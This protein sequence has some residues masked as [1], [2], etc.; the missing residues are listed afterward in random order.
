MVR[1]LRKVKEDKE[2]KEAK[3]IGEVHA[4][5]LVS[6][7]LLNK[8]AQLDQLD[9][10]NQLDQLSQLDQLHVWDHLQNKVVVIGGSKGSLN[11]SLHLKKLLLERIMI[12][13]VQMI[14]TVMTGIVT[15]IPTMMITIKETHT[16]LLMT[17]AGISTAGATIPTSISWRRTLIIRILFQTRLRI[18]CMTMA[19]INNSTSQKT[20]KMIMQDIIHAFLTLESQ[21][22]MQDKVVEFLYAVQD[23]SSRHS[24]KRNSA[25]TRQTTVIK[26]TSITMTTVINI[27]MN[28]VKN[29]SSSSQTWMRQRCNQWNMLHLT[30]TTRSSTISMIHMIMSTYSTMSSQSSIT[31][32]EETCSKVMTSMDMIIAQLHI[33]QW[34]IKVIQWVTKVIL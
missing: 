17:T 9:K 33:T 10:L 16:M 2:V 11:R 24:H 5:P 15:M 26:V 21:D 18:L 1:K 22:R 20:S 34:D 7:L 23:R 30:L 29:C 12:A 19:L 6:N 31:E 3:G 25:L 32:L 14:T 27:V 8:K 28:M 4:N 13:M